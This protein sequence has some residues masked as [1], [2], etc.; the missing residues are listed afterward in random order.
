MSD[1][2]PPKDE[3]P[4]GLLGLLLWPLQAAITAGLA[5]FTAL[6]NGILGALIPK[7]PDQDDDKP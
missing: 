6:V 4:G 1:Q 2:E 3:P 5:L 7:K